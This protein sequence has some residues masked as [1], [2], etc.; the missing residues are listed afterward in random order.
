MEAK[1]Y[2]YRADSDFWAE[3][4]KPLT[5][6]PCED[7]VAVHSGTL[8]GTGFVD[9]G[10]GITLPEEIDGVPVT[11]LSGEFEPIDFIEA[12]C[13][14]RVRL[15]ISP[16][17]DPFGPQVLRCFP[18]HVYSRACEMMELE[19]RAKVM[20]LGSFAR[21]TY[22]RKVVFNGIVEADDNYWDASV[23]GSGLFRDCCNLREVWDIL[24][25]Q[26]LTAAL[27]RAVHH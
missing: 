26:T 12:P 23:F 21:R 19:F 7:G 25:V 8:L 15:R 9:F 18:P 20:R 24:R 10:H 6:S 2:R 4:A 11:E 16:G 22:L 1:K 17:K 5:Y 3:A 13:L 14:K 27:L